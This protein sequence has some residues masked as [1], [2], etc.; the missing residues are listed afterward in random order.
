MLYNVHRLMHGHA[1][2]EHNVLRGINICAIF[3]ISLCILT[4][5]DVLNVH[6]L[7][8]NPFVSFI[9]CEF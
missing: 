6:S 2:T 4:S 9:V 5:L 1:L 3:C 8:L 7:I